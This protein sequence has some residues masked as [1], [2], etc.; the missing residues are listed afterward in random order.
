M[1]DAVLTGLKGAIA[2]A[3]PAGPSPVRR[4]R[5]VRRTSS[6]DTTWPDGLGRTMRMHGRAR[7]IY[8][9]APGGP[10]RLLAEEEVRI[11]AS[12]AREILEIQGGRQ[13]A[14]LQALVGQKG[15]GNLRGVLASLLP[16]ELAA[17]SPLNLLL[18][19]VSG[20]S[21][22]APWAWSRW[23][24]DWQARL[25]AAAPAGERRRRMEGICSGFQPGASSLAEDGAVGSADQSSAPVPPLQRPDDPAGWHALDGQEGVGMRRARRIDVWLED[26][27]VCM[28]VGFQDSATNPAGGPDR[29]AVHEYQVRATA[30]IERFILRSVV[31]EPRV[32]PYR[33]CP[34]ASPNVAR[35][36]GTRLSDLRLAVPRELPGVIGCTHLND[37]LRS[38]SDVPQLVSALQAELARAAP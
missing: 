27:L 26:D 19:D 23:T 37:V 2:P 11:L 35:L 7:D 36:I 28:D 1:S 22:V 3:N 9:S 34:G 18:D 16:D 5:S 29:I 30:D 25:V 12:A 13:D 15:G 17:G 21:L 33:E 6:I 4:G 38:L 24:P 20:A 32:L 10:P 31:A 14:D 8:T